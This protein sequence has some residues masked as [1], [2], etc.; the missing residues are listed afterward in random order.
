MHGGLGVSRSCRFRHWTGRWVGCEPIWTLEKRRRTSCTCREWNHG[1]SVNWTATA[2]SGNL[3]VFRDAS[4]VPQVTSSL[5]DLLVSCT[6][7]TVL[8]RQ[9]LARYCR[10]CIGLYCGH[11]RTAPLTQ[12]QTLSPSLVF[13]G[14]SLWTPNPWGWSRHLLRNT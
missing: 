6:F 7:A 2:R 9:P 11:I 13:A 4:Q 3:K 8:V 1:C 14:V 10:N 12:L 5:W